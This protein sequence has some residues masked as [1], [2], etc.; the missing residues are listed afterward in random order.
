MQQLVARSRKAEDFCGGHIL[1]SS[2]H[3]IE[4]HVECLK[5]LGLSEPDDFEVQN[6]EPWPIER[7]MREHGYSSM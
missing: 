3:D 7:V 5:M 1:L 2:E 6:L 4:A